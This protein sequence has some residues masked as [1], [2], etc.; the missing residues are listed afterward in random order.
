MPTNVIMPALGMAQDT[1][2]LIRWLVDPE[3]GVSKGDPLMEIETDKA[4]VEVEAPATGVLGE[5]TAA[6]GEEIPVGQVIAV[7]FSSD[8]VTPGTRS[9]SSLAGASPPTIAP[10]HENRDSPAEVGSPV[11]APMAEKH[12]VDLASAR[13]Q[14]VRVKAADG[15]A[16]PALHMGRQEYGVAGP[17]LASP[18]ARRL[19]RERGLDL[20][21][22]RGSGPEGAI[23]DTDI[24]AAIAS[25]ATIPAALPSA[26][27]SDVLGAAPSRVVTVAGASTTD[28]T[29]WNL[30][31]KRTTESWTS[32]PHF[33]LER[34]MDA[35][36]LVT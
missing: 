14:G 8:E 6:E 18:K 26:P 17:P 27:S 34:S 13:Q 36:G 20:A 28:G 16:D 2:R 10:P 31:A 3:Q 22:M 1:G 4:T 29:I 33:Y 7:I 25:G 15:R 32:A 5:V 19:A 11:A 24:T 9:V 23:L 21:D 12:D 30:M 35:T